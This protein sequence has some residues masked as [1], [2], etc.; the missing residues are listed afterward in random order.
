[1][2]KL[3]L[4]ILFMLLFGIFKVVKSDNELDIYIANVSLSREII[5]ENDTF[6]LDVDIGIKNL[7]SLNN[8][9]NFLV[10]IFWDTPSKYT[11]IETKNL[12]IKDNDKIRVTFSLDLSKKTFINQNVQ[13][14]GD[15]SLVIQVDSGHNIN[16]YDEKNNI[17]E[18]KIHIFKLTSLILKIWINVKDGYIN[19]KK[20]ELET[21]PIIVNKRTMVPLRFVVEAF[22]GEIYW[23]GSDQSIKIIFSKKEIMMWIGNQVAYINGEKYVLDSPPIVINGRTLVPIRFISEALGSYVFWNPKDMGVTII[24]EK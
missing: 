16:E 24:N 21:P 17:Y 9:T 2:K 3:I 7:I 6:D 18:K 10:S 22:G 1:M 20:V 13:L 5:F 11:H 19:D 14:L 8:P 12:E 4:I 15:K 23:N